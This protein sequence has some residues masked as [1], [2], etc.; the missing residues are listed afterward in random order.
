MCSLG[1]L[2][3]IKVLD[4]EKGNAKIELFENYIAMFI[5]PEIGDDFKAIFI[6]YDY[7]EDAGDDG[8]HILVMPTD[9]SYT[10]LM[11]SYAVIESW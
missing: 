3:F 4:S 8:E 5:V 10:L 7:E 2:G 6:S 1:A 9:Q 11:D